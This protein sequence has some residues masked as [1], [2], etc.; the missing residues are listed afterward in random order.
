M[1][2]HD[3]HIL[4]LTGRPGVGKTT[5]IRRVVDRLRPIGWHLGGFYTEEIRE[6]DT[7]KGFR[8]VTMAGDGVT[9]AHA[10]TGGMPK[11]GKYTVDVPAL[12][13]V[14]EATLRHDAKDAD[15]V[16]I[17]EIGKME[18]LASGFLDATT[19]L[20]DQPLP[21]VATVA[22]SGRGLISEV[23]NRPD[24]RL[25]EV[26]R[27]NRDDLPERIIGWLESRRAALQG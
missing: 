3:E 26:T 7:R 12:D 19:D 22:K 18:C 11:V 24:A 14:A 25:V 15:A 20:L 27:H 17:D 6:R 13:E 9:V 2:S 4:L 8:A 21:L 5:V 16:I 23:K 1:S 10:D